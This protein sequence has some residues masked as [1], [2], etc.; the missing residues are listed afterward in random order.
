MKQWIQAC[1]LR[2]LP[3]ALSSIFVGSA[4][5]M[6][7]YRFS[8]SI[9]LLASLTAIM[10]QI[11]SNLANDY[12]DFINGVDND[13]RKGP[14]R[15]L[16][17]GALQ[18]EQM[19]KSIQICIGLSLLMGGGLLIT[20][21]NGIAIGFWILFSFLGISSIYAALRYT[22]GKKPYGYKGYGDLFVFLFF[23]IIG[24]LGTF[25]LHTKVVDWHFLL[26]A[27]SIGFFCAAVLNINNIRDHVADEQNGKR[28]LVVQMG[29]KKAKWYH[30]GLNLTGLCLAIIFVATSFVSVWS[31]LFLLTAPLFLIPAFELINRVD[32]DNFDPYL[33]KQCVATLLFSLLFS[34]GINI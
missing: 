31:L 2:T 28:T 14:T 15:A 12:G 17:S 6:A 8:L 29:I 20:A 24:T 7:Q 9:F 5:A 25:F 33:K 10:L 21:L 26:P 30:V 27:S 22:M 11:T 16:Q 1:R 13:K 3:L 34:I 32:Y 23:G 18:P 4:L 19:L